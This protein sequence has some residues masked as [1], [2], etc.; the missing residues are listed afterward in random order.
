LYLIEKI[1]VGII[2]FGLSGRVFHAPIITSVSGFNLAKIYTT[3][4]ENIKLA[5]ER[6]P[7]AL[8]V[9]NM[10]DIMK[11]ESIH[12][13]IVA[14]P[15]SSHYSIA[16][17]AILLG[18]HV[19]IEKPFTVTSE[20]ADELITLAYINGTVLSVYHNRRWDSDFKTVKKI[21]ESKKLGNLV[22]C[23][24]HYDRFRPLLKENTWK[25]DCNPGSG[26]LYDLG[27]HL[28]DQAQVLFGL[29]NDIT[30]DLR[31]QRTGSKIIDNFTMVLNYSNLS[32]PNL[33][34][35][36]KS[37]LLIKGNIPRYMLFGD[38]GS[39]IKYGLDTQEE[40]LKSGHTPLTRNDWGK[41]PEEIYGLLDTI[42]DGAE[43]IEKVESEIG[44]YREYYT[45]IYKAIILKQDV[46]VKA[47]QARNTIRLIELA[48]ESSRKK[49]TLDIQCYGELIK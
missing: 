47:E 43:R 40:A 24:L 30:A 6:Y 29:P 3:N 17:E 34:V 5:N 36:I 44:D 31:V 32:Y 11:D 14:A 33:K 48:I 20:E 41:E 13:V 9:S 39:F 7:Q 42:I 26:I 45:N 37:G 10:K 21:V 46:A 23:E 49:C 38:K 27:S 22:E 1:N 19:I 12:L 4:C 8:V 35:T 16:K 18:K 15:N 25:E 28:I 2:G